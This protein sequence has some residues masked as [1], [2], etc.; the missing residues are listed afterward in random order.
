MLLRDFIPK[1]SHVA[2]ITDGEIDWAPGYSVTCRKSL[3]TV[4]ARD[5]LENDL[6]SFSSRIATAG[7]A[8]GGHVAA[9]AADVA[10]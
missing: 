3:R 5:E 1:S 9:C 7:A 4:G 6:S 10:A 2:C 8:R